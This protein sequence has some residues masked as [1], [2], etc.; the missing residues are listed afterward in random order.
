[1]SLIAL[2][3]LLL[4]ISMGLVVMGFGL[5]AK[6][7]DVLYLL[8][9]PIL[10]LRSILAMNIIMPVVAIFMVALFN[11]PVP[12]KIAIVALALSPVPPFLPKLQTGAG[13]EQ[14]YIISLLAIAAILAI[15]IVPYGTW[16]IGE[17]FNVNGGVAPA[18]NVIPTVLITV[19][20]P[21]LVGEGLRQF[22]PEIADRITRPVALIG[23]GLMVLS[24]L[25]ILFGQWSSIVSMVGNGT[26]VILAI[27]SGV[28]LFVGH[29][30]GVKDPDRGV[31]A[32]ATAVRHP[33]VALTIAHSTF[34]DQTEVLAVVLWHL[35]VGA[36]LAFAYLRFRPHAKAGARPAHT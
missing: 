24:L 8:R 31:L 10:L 22:A 14:G 1:M 28:G 9:R 30:F 16:L 17:I 36:L 33:G 20:I 7:V 35:I 13:G 12:L 25:P 27:F 26:L 6:L 3:T 5:N 18:I 15:I 2:L 34:P 4:N 19:V 32:L 29:Y 23:T 21:L 11:I